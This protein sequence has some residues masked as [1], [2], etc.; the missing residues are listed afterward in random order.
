MDRAQVLRAELLKRELAR[1]GSKTSN[2]QVAEIPKQ[3]MGN[4]VLKALP[5]GIMSMAGQPSVVNAV[6]TPAAINR[7]SVMMALGD[8]T[9]NP[10]TA[11]PQN[12][13][14]LRDKYIPEGVNNLLK[15][16]VLKA[17]I[18][19]LNIM[20]QAANIPDMVVDPAQMLI[21]AMGGKVMEMPSAKLAGQEMGNSISTKIESLQ[22]LLKPKP[23]DA[24]V[25]SQT[26]KSSKVANISKQFVDGME[27]TRK[28]VGKIQGDWI[29]AHASDPVDSLDAIVDNLPDALKAE[30]YS[31]PA[32][33][34]ITP[35]T[36][37]AVPDALGVP[38]N[39]TSSGSIQIE[40]TLK[41]AETIRGITKGYL[42][43]KKWN[44][45]AV[46]IPA[47]NAANAG[48]DAIGSIMKKGRPELATRMQD[49][50]EV[51]DA[52]NELQRKLQ[53]NSGFSKSKP[54]EG[55]YRKDAESATQKAIDVL[56]KH[57]EG[58][59]I[60]RDQALK[61][62]KSAEFKELLQKAVPGASIVGGSL[63]AL[64]QIKKAFKKS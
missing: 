30:I 44:Y 50:S 9:A 48:Y 62:A 39:K 5:A 32:I 40:P 16:N 28:K 57:N 45:N 53:T 4:E 63:V 20:D 47:Q 21:G 31:N 13:P 55:I 19:P 49:Y 22:K 17:G 10:M 54:V 1:R 33:T 14:M 26:A 7:A 37:T 2:S 12:T 35:T 3:S 60:P 61:L 23:L 15:N 8:K 42:P 36:T 6:E 41:N 52:V 11:T 29:D 51:M 25:A 64:D 46:D 24:K 58:M 38:V 43:A 59:K 34:K 27:T 18:L 56:T